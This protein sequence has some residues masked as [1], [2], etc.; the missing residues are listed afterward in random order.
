MEIWI[1]IFADLADVFRDLNPAG[2]CTC[3][4]T[5]LEPFGEVTVDVAVC[6]QLVAVGTRARQKARQ[7]SVEALC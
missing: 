1:W 6:M 7:Q 2:S 5:C 4:P 3:F